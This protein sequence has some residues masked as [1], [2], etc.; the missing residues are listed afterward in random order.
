MKANR[1]FI[2]CVAAL[3]LVACG[4]GTELTAVLSGAAEKP[5][6]V[7]TTGSGSTDVTVDGKK[8]EVTGSFKDL[9]GNA[10]AAH[11]HGPADAS[12]TAG[13]FCN[14]TV[15]AAASGSITTDKNAGS[16]G[17]IELTEA[18]VAD[19]E[20]GKYYINIH[21]AANANGEIRGQL[22]KKE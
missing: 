19:F 2:A 8:I 7:T 13:V 17:A 6:A 14:L 5:S 12:S 20:A 3:S 16:C 10:T 1:L 4:G 21:T 9:S 15:P 18:Q 11:I 22:I